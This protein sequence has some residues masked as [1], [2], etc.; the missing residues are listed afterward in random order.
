M[1]IKIDYGK[2]GVIIEVPDNATVLNPKHKEKIDNQS[3]GKI[4]NE[5]YTFAEKYKTDPMIISACLMIVAKD[6][7]F[8]FYGLDFPSGQYKLKNRKLKFF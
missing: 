1:K 8:C 4:L 3:Q 2:N 6:I 5:V 7:Y